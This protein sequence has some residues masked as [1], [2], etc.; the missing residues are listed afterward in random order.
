MSLNYP[1]SKLCKKKE[2]SYNIGPHKLH[3]PQLPRTTV[4]D[5]SDSL[6]S[7]DENVTNNN[8]VSTPTSPPLLDSSPSDLVMVAWNLRGSGDKVTSAAHRKR[9]RDSK[10]SIAFLSEVSINS[11]DQQVITEKAWQASCHTKHVY[12]NPSD[13]P[14][15]RGGVGIIISAETNAKIEW[16]DRVKGGRCIFIKGTFNGCKQILISVHL[17]NMEAQQVKFLRMLHHKMAQYNDKNY[18]FTLGGDHNVTRYDADRLG[19][20]RHH[21]KR[22]NNELNK[23]LEEFQLIDVY[24][25]FHKGPAYTWHAGKVA[26]R[27]DYF[28]S[29]AAWKPNVKSIEISLANGLSD[30]EILIMTVE[31]DN[32]FP[33][34]PGTWKFNDQ[35]LEE[36]Q[37]I[38]YMEKCIMEQLESSKHN[39][40]S[41]LRYELLKQMIAASSRKYA[42]LRAQRIRDDEARLITDLQA[43]MTAFSNSLSDSNL[44]KLND[45]EQ[46]LRQI[47]TT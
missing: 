38:T 13:N 47:A 32:F 17:P 25:A 2:K 21:R 31:S 41:H 26:R 11:I 40:D 35:L 14:T 29:P 34:G 33:K 8:P 1:I 4:M 22:T 43:A 7:V 15:S 18:A 27:L 24:R 3:F 37:F 44:A 10:F 28:F 42:K 16:V 46:E 9:L 30:H 12:F 5:I 20:S 45:I 19:G 6:E 36:P 23:I 39:K